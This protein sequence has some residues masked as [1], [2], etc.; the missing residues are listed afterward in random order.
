MK[1]DWQLFSDQT[2]P[3]MS[4]YDIRSPNKENSETSYS[5][6]QM[7]QKGEESNNRSK[8]RNGIVYTSY[9]DQFVG[10][11]N[12]HPEDHVSSY[13]DQ[14]AQPQEGGC[15]QNNIRLEH[16]FLHKRHNIPLHKLPR[17]SAKAE[18]QLQA[19]LSELALVEGNIL[20]KKRSTQ[21][22]YMTSCFPGEGKTTA[23]V[24]TAYALA[25]L[26]GKSVALI[27]GQTAH[28]SIHRMF[29]VP[30][31]PGLNDVIVSHASLS[32]VIIPTSYETLHI[33][34][35]GTSSKRKPNTFMDTFQSILQELRTHFDFVIYDGASILHA[36]ELSAVANIFD[37][38][39]L[40]VECER[41][42]W[43]VVHMAEE[44]IL[45][46]QGTILGVILNKRKYYI[47]RMIYRLMSR[48]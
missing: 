28:P 2:S 17:L 43:E 37:G 36:S 20:A 47:P 31:S 3:Q 44:K 48:K 33:I 45:N 11:P 4:A 46:A 30:V 14:F 15:A 1:K 13:A 8:R 25:M 39:V 27:D 23:A 6:A 19:N 41:T 38:V 10:M 26:S 29:N 42:K 12:S 35:A 21:T 34:P 24:T 7:Y 32:Q 5:Y 40:I 16:D 9:E 18:K 22:I